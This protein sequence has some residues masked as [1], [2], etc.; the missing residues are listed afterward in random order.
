MSARAIIVG[1]MMA[2]ATLSIAPAAIDFSP[3]F[4]WNAS[5]SVPIGLYRV[6]PEDHL[7]VMDLV[8][9]MPPEPIAKFLADRNFLPRGVPLLKQVLGLP[10]QT[11]C[12]I[13]LAVMIDGIVMAMARERDRRGRPLPAWHGCRTIAEG[14]VFLMNWESGDS[15]DG[16]YFGPLP[17]AS[18]IG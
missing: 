4:I 10:G 3:A 17:A 13:C 12:R 1:T 2:S 7:A 6:L 9:L 5:A 8:V 15:L 16:R 14:E 18:I 11:V